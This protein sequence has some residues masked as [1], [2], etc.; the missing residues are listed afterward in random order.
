MEMQL[1]REN[2]ETEQVI[3]ARPTQVAVEAEV[4][5]PGGLREEARVYYADAV[6]TVNGGEAAGSRI[7]A[8]G[9]VTFH[10][11]YAQGDLS[12][13]KALETAADFSHS[14][15]I[16][17]EQQ[18]SAMRIKPRAE[19]Q[20]VSAKAF[21]GRLL[22]QAIVNLTAEASL[23][24]TLS[25]VRN[26]TGGEEIQRSTQVLSMQ[27][28]VGEGESQTLLREEF[29]LSDVL[30]I[31]ETLY[32]TAQAQVEDI[33]GGSDGR[34]TV[35][36]TISL[37][38]YHTADMPGRPLVYTRH[39][40]PFEQV[41]GLS[42]ALGDALVSRSVVKDVAVLSQ[43]GEEGGKSM[44]A[45]VQLNTELFAVKGEEMEAL[46]DVFTTGGEGIETRS[47]HVL[48]R[49][50][51]VNDQTAESGKTVLLLPE[52]SPR[53][54][55]ALLA[56]ARP[57]VVKAEPQG[58]KLKVD[59]I[60]ETTLIY[61]TE[62]SAVPISI[63]QEEPFQALFSTEALPEDTLT[64]TASQAEA[65]PITGDRVELKY[66]LR[67]N[68]EGV[69]KTEADVIIDAVAAEAPT[70]EKGIALYFMQPGD[71]L[72]EIAK[73]YR[74]PTEDIAILNPQLSDDPAP[75]TPIITYKR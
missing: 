33:L 48:F 16:R 60:L 15:P 41:V 29:E 44:R 46:R 72:W 22:L 43:E 2:M 57:I 32:A 54:K 18:L 12:H 65:S 52:G 25:F 17:E 63:N 20:H 47:Q 55:T 53:V 39:S 31:K 70:T 66:I 67:L 62:D 35:T 51:T 59:G 8:D 73:R 34:A 1:L 69:R 23:P 24:R 71:T 75:G 38:A 9:R 6:A 3:S 11:L 7:S 21:N 27:R 4:T 26:V 74:I 45:E 68:A 10:V 13:V 14:L 30:Q 19:V 28:V 42:G 61:Q 49:S 37:E 56:F 36:G 50:G 64:L 40:M 5:L 58:G